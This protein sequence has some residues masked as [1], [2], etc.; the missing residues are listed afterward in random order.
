MPTPLRSRLLTAV[1]LALLALGLAGCADQGGD[2]AAPA[3]PV[4]TVTA[5]DTECRV[6]ADTAP[7][8]T[9]TFRITN[10][11]TKVNEFYVYAAG[12]RVVGEVENLTPGITRE[13]KAELTEPGT[14][15]TACKPGMAGNGIRDG[16]TVTAA[17]AASGSTATP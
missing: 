15:E 3:G 2:T 16:F 7:A 4:I 10:E 12:D 1:P 11:G 6:S 17:G 8:G 5:T 14:Y 9:V 13:L